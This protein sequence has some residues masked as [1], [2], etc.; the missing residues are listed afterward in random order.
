MALVHKRQSLNSR[1]RDWS[2]LPDD[3]IR[4]VLGRL[5]FSDFHRARAVCS[6]WYRVWGECVPKPNQ[7]PWLILF[8][9]PAQT[10][11]SCMLYNPQEEENVYTI[12]DL[13]VDPCLASC[14]TWL[15]MSDPRLNLYLVN[16]LNLERINLVAI[17]SQRDQLFSALVLDRKGHFASK[18]EM[19]GYPSTDKAVVWIDEKTKDYV[20]A[21]SWDGDKHAAF[22]KKGDCE[23]RPIPSLLGCSD[24]ALKDHKLY[25]YYEDGSIG[26]SDLKFVTKTAHV[27]LYPFRFHLGSL[28]PYE[29]IWADYLDW[30]TNI[31]ITISGDFL[32]VGSVLKRRDLSW[33]FRVYKFNSANNEWEETVSLGDQAVILDLGI[34]VQASSDIQGIT[35]NSIYFSGLPS[36]QKD[37]FV[38]NL[39]SQKVQRLSSSSVSSRPFS[40]ARWLFPTS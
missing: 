31:V 25:I 17:E 32:M 21:C 29:T 27:Q 34:T 33:L 37:V 36:S 3:V 40:N 39:S 38:F 30:K 19:M 24:I 28:S 22:C 1:G 10:R 14:G 26:I 13:G 8:P 9:D 16:V 6:A 11:R 2:E 20:V 12:Q 35:R 7:V 23:W 18:A 15:L 5:R 4:M